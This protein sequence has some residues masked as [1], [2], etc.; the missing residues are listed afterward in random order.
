MS[1]R[2]CTLE[3]FIKTS[4]NSDFGEPCMYVG[5]MVGN[6]VPTKNLKNIP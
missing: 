4:H 3:V 6:R 2:E 1:H 5:N